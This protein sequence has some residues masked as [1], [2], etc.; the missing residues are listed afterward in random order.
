MG[1]AGVRIDGRSGM[2][3]KETGTLTPCVKGRRERAR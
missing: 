2:S 1:R 3:L